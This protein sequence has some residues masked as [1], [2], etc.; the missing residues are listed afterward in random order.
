M[1]GMCILVYSW[2]VHV[3]LRVC[4]KQQQRAHGQE[5]EGNG[6]LVYSKGD[7]PYH[8][9]CAR[10]QEA[11]VEWECKHYLSVTLVFHIPPLCMFTTQT[12]Y[13]IHTW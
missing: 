1:L 9:W 2:H 8:R 4:S 13:A 11:L 7:L 12:Y 3:H 10:R 5:E 6:Q